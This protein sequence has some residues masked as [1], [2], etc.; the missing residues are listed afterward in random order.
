MCGRVQ[1]VDS[2]DTNKTGI[3]HRS[4]YSKK[5]K[6]LELDILKR[7]SRRSGTED[8]ENNE[9]KGHERVFLKKGQKKWVRD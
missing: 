1:T 9:K 3:R 8:I 2:K 5:K 7:G 6:V 4:F